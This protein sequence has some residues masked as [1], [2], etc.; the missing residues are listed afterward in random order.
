MKKLLLILI[1]TSLTAS[2]KTVKR[3]KTSSKSFNNQEQISW[4][5]EGHLDKQ[6]TEERTVKTGSGSKGT[7]STYS[8]KIV[9]KERIHLDSTGK[10]PVRIDRETTS[11]ETGKLQRDE[12]HL[13][14]AAVVSLKHRIDSTYQASKDSTAATAS[15]SNNTNQVQRATAFS[16]WWL[17]FAVAMFFF[18]VQK[19]KSMPKI[20]GPI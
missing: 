11:E 1:V 19:I 6:K 12:T 15:A 14:S 8:R 16:M 10:K 7:D 3:S 2:C 4:R 17:V 13:D 18:V 9:T 20:S 5:T